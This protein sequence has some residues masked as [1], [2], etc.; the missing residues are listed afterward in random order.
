[1]SKKIL[2]DAGHYTNYNQSAVHKA[3][4]E[5]NA[6]WTLQKYLKRELESYGFKVDVTRVSRDKDLSLNAR[7]SMARGYDCFI[8]LHSNAC[9]SE[10]VDRVVIIKG[11]DQPDTL[12]AK[13]GSELTKVMGVKQKYQIMTRKTTSGGEYYGVLRSSKAAG[14]ADRF[15]IEHGFHTNT[16]TA[17]W[18]CDENNLK[19]IAQAEAKILAEHYKVNKPSKPT[20]T[21]STSTKTKWSNGDYNCKVK[22]TANLNIR[23]GRGTDYKVIK[24]IPKGTVFTV[25]YVNNNWGSTWD[26][27]KV[28]Y[29]S[30]DYIDK[31]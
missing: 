28:G 21:T 4:Y 3:Y 8:S 14:V 26:F 19:K 25:G 24:T 30:C 31:V 1:M 18:L 20:G 17:K 23:E 29:F 2:L 10:S 7:G 9:G 15:I 22:A 11:Y 6:M 13:F 16:N 27:G 12:A 5:G